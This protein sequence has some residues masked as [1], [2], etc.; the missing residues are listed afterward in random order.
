MCRDL[1][2]QVVTEGLETKE[3]IDFITSCSCQVAQG[4]YYARPLNLVEFEEFASKHKNDILD[5]FLFRLDNEELTSTDG[6][7]RAEYT[8]RDLQGLKGRIVSGW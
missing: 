4:F 7:L 3:Q 2:I 6:S 8:G 1:K 5:S